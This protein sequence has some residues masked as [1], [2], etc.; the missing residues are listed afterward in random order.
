MNNSDLI[1]EYIR[2]KRIL[3]FSEAREQA[4]EISAALRVLFSHLPPGEIDDDEELGFGLDEKNKRF[5]IFRNPADL[6]YLERDC[7]VRERSGLKTY[8][9]NKRSYNT[10]PPSEN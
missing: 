1:S 7:T 6:Y 10:L 2:L 3:V 5:V 8:F 4:E 9:K